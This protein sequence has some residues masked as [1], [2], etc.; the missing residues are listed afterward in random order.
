MEEKKQIPLTQPE[1]KSYEWRAKE[2]TPQIYTN[3]ANVS[4]TLFDVRFVFGQLIPAAPG[5]KQFIVEERASVTFA[6]P[7]AKALRDMLVALIAQ[8][9]EVNGEIKPLKIPPAPP[10]FIGL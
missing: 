6:W 3:F 7:E 2:G 10:S 4:W 8:Y 9:E 5:T 1:T